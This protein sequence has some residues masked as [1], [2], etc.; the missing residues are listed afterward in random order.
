M[1]QVLDHWPECGRFDR[2]REN[3]PDKPQQGITAFL[4]DNHKPG[5]R[6]AKKLNGF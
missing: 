6:M 4:V 2:L 1:K 3:I 5:S